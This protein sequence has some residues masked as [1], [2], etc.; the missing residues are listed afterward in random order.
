MTSK[1]LQ[2]TFH[3][4]PNEVDRNWVLVDADNQTL[5]R[6]ATKIADVLRGKN[7][8]TFTPSTDAGDF[9]VVINAKHVNLTGKK[10]TQKLYHSHSGFPGGYK[11]A[12]V[13]DVR[14]K[15]P[16]R[17]IVNA[18]KGMLPHNK[19]GNKLITKLKVYSGSEHGHEAQA[20]KQ[21]EINS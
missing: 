9:V 14:E 20:P 11:A 6:L 1:R 4:K 13:K 21:V 19:L 3:A 16:E 17:L 5:G 15:H 10:E 18:V 12:S 8:P 2:K 7:K